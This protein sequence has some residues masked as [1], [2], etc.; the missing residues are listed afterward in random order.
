[1]RQ[2]FHEDHIIRYPPLSD[3]ARQELKYVLFVGTPARLR[4]DY[5]QGTFLPNGMLNSDYSSLE[6]IWMR[7]REV[8]DLNRGN[9]F[10][11]GF[12]DVLQ[13]IGKLY[14]AIGVDGRDIASTQT[15]HLDPQFLHLLP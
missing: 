12:Y 11:T 15:I 14:I 7:Y 2:G 8:L 9:P 6:H 3:L 10:T 4:L 5:Q 1:M 13:S